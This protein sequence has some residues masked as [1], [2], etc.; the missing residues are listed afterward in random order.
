MRVEREGGVAAWL[1]GTLAASRGY[2]SLWCLGFSLWWLLGHGAQALGEQAS[3]A[4]RS[5][6]GGHENPLQHSCLEIPKDKGAWQATVQGVTKTRLKQLSTHTRWAQTSACS[7]SL[8]L[9][10]RE[11]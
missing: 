5:P 3:V 2:S 7:R 11:R 8:L 10:G 1:A 9:P 6:G 4:V